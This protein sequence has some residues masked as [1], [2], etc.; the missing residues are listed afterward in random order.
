MSKTNEERAPGPEAPLGRLVRRGLGWSVV[1]QVGNRLGVF[2]TG[3]VLARVLTPED[4]GVYAVA[5]VAL[6]LLMAVNEL[7]V[8][9]SIVRWQGDPR[10]VAPTGMT[11]AFVNSMALYVLV[12]AGAPAFSSALN[13]PE[14]TGVV[15]L[16]ALSVVVDGAVAV[17]L[18]LLAR[19]FRQ[20]RQAVAEIVGMLAYAAVAV[21]LASSGAGA[22][23]I[24]L[25]RVAGSVATGLLLMLF[26]PFRCLPAFDRAVA[27][28]IIRFGLPLAASS[29]VRH[30]VLNVDYLIVGHLLGTATLGVYLLAF[31][32]SSWP[33]STVS[34]AVARVAFAGFSRLVHDRARL[35]AGFTKALALIVLASLPIVLVLIVLAPELIRFVYGPK[36][37]PA[38][39]AVR[40]LLILGGL[41]VAIDLMADLVSADGRPQLNLLVQL[42]WLVALVPALAVGAQLGDIRGVGIAHM[43]VAL[44]V[45]L[46]VAL[47]AVR[48]SG[49]RLGDLLP[50]TARPLLG[51]VAAASLMALLLDVAAGDLLRLVLV[52]GGAMIAYAVVAL[53][54]N[55]VVTGF[56]SRLSPTPVETA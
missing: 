42:A 15:R 3:I 5:L 50:L 21:V 16:L 7:G 49:V 19:S 2:A 34:I 22:L 44:V 12:F 31:N 9:P 23:S 55:P 29:L 37:L 6:N 14:A 20:D 51:T 45:V 24:A 56:R 10:A 8:I 43:V 54:F 26:A 18:A 36:W 48:R 17:P 28:T 53:P 11:L 47:A 25:G 4:F 27:R 13:A 52:G 30:A 32:L 40:F 33:V 39:T 46:P 41:R 35:V 38:V 1:G